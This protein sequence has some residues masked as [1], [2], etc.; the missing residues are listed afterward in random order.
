MSNQL[1][2]GISPPSTSSSGDFLVKIFQ[3]PARARALLALGAAYGM[4]FTEWFTSLNRNGSS[5]KMLHLRQAVGS[6]PFV[7]DWNSSDMTRF[8]FL[9]RRSMLALRTLD[10]AFLLLRERSKRGH[11]GDGD[12]EEVELFP[13]PSACEYGT[14]QGG[15]AGRTGKVRP[16]L[17]TMARRGLWQ[18]QNVPNGGRVNSLDM[19]PTGQMPDGK[20]RQVDLAHQ[21]KMVETGRWPTPTAGDSVASGSRDLPRSKAHPGVSLTDAVRTGNSTTPR[22]PQWPTPK[23]SPSGP[24]FAR[25]CREGSVGDDLATAVARTQKRWGTP[26]GQMWKGPAKWENRKRKGKQRPECDKL[27]K[28]QVFGQ[29][30]P[31]WVEWLM[32]FPPGWTDLDV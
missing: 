29:L 26:T 16:S 23:G 21:V 17:S 1:D 13:T 27:L 15:Q 2:L 12:Q 28:D 4:S 6:I 25:A 7:G 24:D 14:N 3:Q 10:A 22:R 11:S 8:Q 20:K 18:T 30:N 5:S 31:T 32:G 19:S 9:C